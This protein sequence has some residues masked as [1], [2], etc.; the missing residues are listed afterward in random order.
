MSNSAPKI[1]FPLNQQL[2]K[3][4]GIVQMKSNNLHTIH[5]NSNGHEEFTIRLQ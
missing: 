1:A 4:I 5:T 2:H 3:M